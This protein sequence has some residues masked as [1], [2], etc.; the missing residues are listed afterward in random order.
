MNP[1]SARLHAAAQV[2]FARILFCEAYDLRV[3]EAASR[4]RDERLG[5]PVLLSN[6]L[7][8]EMQNR[9]GD[10][11]IE[12]RAE[13]GASRE[14]AR[15]E[16]A[17]PLLIAAL[18]V[19]AGLVD[20][21][22]A[23]AVATTATT[24]RAALRGIGTAPDCSTVSSSMLLHCPPVRREF[25]FADCA[26]VPN[27]TAEQLADI[28]VSASETARSLLAV[29]PRVA[30]L[31]FSTHGSASHQLA[32]KVARATALVR[33]RRPDLTIDGELQL[34]A[35]IVPELAHVK[36][37]GSPVAGNAD[38]LVFPNLD[39][40]NIGY[41]LL[42][43]LGGSNAVGPILQGLAHPMND[44]SRGATVDEIIDLA[45]VTAAQA[46]SSPYRQARTERR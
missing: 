34:D 16:L 29:E 28:A 30:M 7:L 19:R 43:R 44:L 45:C 6:S 3:R 5:G 22:I 13:R 32:D 15:T 14:Q 36:A 27:P 21:A 2:R 24:V 9:L 40:A 4:F 39:A 23:G 46:H 38:V 20:G 41:K 17:D 10:E 37:A 1:L 25:V 8:A 12:R 35:A 33:A 42:A 31:S 11:Y 18:M 26:V